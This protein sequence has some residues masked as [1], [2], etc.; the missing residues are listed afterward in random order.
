MDEVD[1]YNYNSI[2]SKNKQKKAVRDSYRRSSD[3][4]NSD[5]LPSSVVATLHRA[6][7]FLL[8]MSFCRLPY[9][10]PVPRNLSARTESIEN[11]CSVGREKEMKDGKNVLRTVMAKF[12][13]QIRPVPNFRQLRLDFSG[14]CRNRNWNKKY[15]VFKFLSFFLVSS[16]GDYLLFIFVRDNGL[17]GI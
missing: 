4:D 10:C 2:R 3:G 15:T 7:Y 12:S 11:K 14:F 13:L 6:L 17:V 16:R 1:I 9:T 8:R 5:K